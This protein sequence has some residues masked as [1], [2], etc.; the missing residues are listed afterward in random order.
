MTLWLFTQQPRHYTSYTSAAPVQET[1]TYYYYY[2]YYFSIFIQD[3]YNHIPE[4]NHVSRVYS[5]AAIL[6]L[7]FHI[8][9][10]TVITVVVVVVVVVVWVL[11]PQVLHWLM[12]FIITGF[13]HNNYKCYQI[14]HSTACSKHC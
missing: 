3:I 8:I 14:L 5:V 10:V 6:Y 13:Y 7:Q 2:Y 1:I 4:A 12:K 11:L 9:T